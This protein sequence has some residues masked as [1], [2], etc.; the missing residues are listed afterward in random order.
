[1]V[2][3]ARAIYSKW[4]KLFHEIDSNGIVFDLIN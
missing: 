1:M 3:L 2:F 4:K